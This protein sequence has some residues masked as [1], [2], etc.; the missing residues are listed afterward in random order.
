MLFLNV[1]SFV[2]KHSVMQK[3][4]EKKDF[5][6]PKQYI[7]NFRPQM[8]LGIIICSMK[9]YHNTVPTCSSNITF[10]K[11]IS[12]FYCNRVIDTQIGSFI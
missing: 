11:Y 1:G 5:G 3:D 4:G 7:D 8:L 10:F 6:H 12:E 2:L 9:H